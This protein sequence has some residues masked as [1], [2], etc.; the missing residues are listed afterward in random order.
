MSDSRYKRDLEQLFKSGADV[1]ERFKSL[2]G[3]IK[4]GADTDPERAAAIQGLRDAGDFRSFAGAVRDYRKAGH[5]LPDDEDLLV[6]MLDLP[7]ERTLA[8]VLTH[9]LALER[10]R[11][12]ERKTPIRNRLTTLRSLA[13]DP[14]TTAL[15]EQIAEIV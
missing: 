5:A 7:D 12:F 11:G 8:A 3:N 10:R 1:P 4:D 13:E 14:E 6:R 15:I 2:V 9:I